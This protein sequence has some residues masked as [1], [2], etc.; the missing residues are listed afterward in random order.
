MKWLEQGNIFTST[1]FSSA[2]N[3][4][5]TKF[6]L[7]SATRFAVLIQFWQ[8]SKCR[9]NR[10]FRRKNLVFHWR[11]ISYFVF[12]YIYIYIY[13]Y[14]IFIYVYINIR[15]ISRAAACLVTESQQY[16]HSYTSCL[17]IF[18]NE[19]KIVMLQIFMKQ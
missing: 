17:Y 19:K 6:L 3:S 7:I 8:D 15:S 1:W 13:I 12:I 11:K 9:R 2:Q 16:F 5:I 10:T 4:F 18:S 14:I